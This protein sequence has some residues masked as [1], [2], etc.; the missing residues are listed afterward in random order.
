MMPNDGCRRVATILSPP[1]SCHQ[2]SAVARASSSARDG[3][4]PCDRVVGVV[5]LESSSSFGSSHSGHHSSVWSI[6][7]YIASHC[8]EGA[9]ILFRSLHQI[10]LDPDSRGS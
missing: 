7:S 4:R 9:A 6:L 5:A 3:G 1:S 8:Q 2:T 10:V